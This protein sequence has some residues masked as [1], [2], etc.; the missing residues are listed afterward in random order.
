MLFLPDEMISQR[1]EN[2]NERSFYLKLF[3]LLWITHLMYDS[4]FGAIALFYP[5]DRRLYDITG[6]I[7]MILG[8]TRV[9]L[10]GIFIDVRPIDPEIGKNIFFVNW[11]AEERVAYFGATRIK[12]R[13][14]DFMVH[15]TIFSYWVITVAW[16]AIAVIGSRNEKVKTLMTKLKF[17]KL[18]F[19]LK[20]IFSGRTKY[21]A[22]VL[23]SIALT[24]F[25]AGPNYG[26]S[27][28]FEDQG[29]VSFI[30]LSDTLRLFGSL[31]FSF[32]EKA[33]ATFVVSFPKSS[34]NYSV[35]WGVLNSTVRQ[36]ID[37][38]TNTFIAEFEQSNR[39]YSELV[40]DYRTQLNRSIGSEWIVT[41]VHNASAFAFTIEPSVGEGYRSISLGFGLYE[42]N[43]TD[44]F[45]RSTTINVKYKIPRETEY[46]NGWIIFFLA[47]AVT[48]L[49]VGRKWKV[50]TIQKMA[51]S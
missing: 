29:E 2:W 30:V 51:E 5:I 49:V 43:L 38:F 9:G 33:E 48:V 37:N 1:I 18:D 23:I 32:P 7:I 15:A 21:Q 26:E 35:I 42:W 31:D 27:W 11:T 8:S 4:S 10:G 50:N 6:G 14:L 16:P 40:E 44:Y 28:E 24:A 12:Y 46:R 34:I 22:A 39:T 45:I 19:T 41:E 13:I 25:M 47:I 20:N 17:P 36:L 3:G